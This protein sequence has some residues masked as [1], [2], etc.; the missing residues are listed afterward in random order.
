[1]RR[2]AV[3]IASA[4]INASTIPAVAECNSIKDIDASRALGNGISGLH[5]VTASTLGPSRRG[6]LWR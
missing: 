4:A 3:L 6:H 5:S 1:M 2:T